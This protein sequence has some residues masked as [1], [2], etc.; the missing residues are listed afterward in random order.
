VIT[1]LT[2]GYI[3]Y[4][5]RPDKENLNTAAA[6]RLDKPEKEAK[7]KRTS[8]AEISEMKAF[9]VCLFCIAA[10]IAFITP[11]VHSGWTEEVRLTHRFLEIYPQ[12]AARGDT[13]HVAWQ[14][15]AGTKH[16][17]YLRST[18]GG[19]IWSEL[20]NLEDTATHYGVRQDLWLTPDY[21]FVGWEDETRQ[22]FITNIG[23]TYSP[24]GETWPAP[25]YVFSDGIRLYDLG[26]AAFRDSIYAVYHSRLLDSTGTHPLRFLYSSDMGATWSDEVTVG[27]VDE[28]TNFLHM[29]HCGSSLYIV[30]A[31][32]LAPLGFYRE[33]MAVVSHDGGLSWSEVMQ[34][35]SPDT[36]VAQFTC[37]ACDEATGH[38]AV[39]WM[40]YSLSGGF[41]GDL[42]IRLTTDGGYTWLPESHA[43]D[44]H[45]V[46][47]SS[48][49]I[50]GDSIWAVWAN[51][52]PS[53]GQ[54]DQEICFTRSTD[55]GAS[56][57][58]RERLSHN[59]EYS[60][61]PGIAYDGGKLHVVW[62]NDNPPPEGG[63]DIYYKRFEPETGIEGELDRN[64]PN[65]IKLSAYPNP[66]NSNLWISIESQ[67]PGSIVIYDILG[68]VIAELEYQ[69]GSNL[70]QWDA[71]DALGN[72]V[73][74][75]IYFARAR[76]PHESETIKLLYLK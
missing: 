44:Y 4:F 28:Y 7:F 21:I 23:Y 9:E 43:T 63:R 73:S 31:S 46:S 50:V 47:I 16:V 39:G 49:A 42:Y 25:G 1:L 38:F 59:P 55:L 60:F 58:P 3:K 33:V 70:I 27:H 22:G 45:G 61:A 8:I 75:G 53:H 35:S 62:Y 71:T 11:I 48:L 64:R 65:R 54:F 10:R 76:A 66:S 26:T 32:D 14:Q 51:R 12:V 41:P 13:V 30:W 19:N 67:E 57:S 34:L 29:A 20:R 37:V 5:S 36:A 24:D 74:S 52:D 2:C 40:D 15:I 6:D 68:R 72:K 17:S 18:D 69:S 56:W